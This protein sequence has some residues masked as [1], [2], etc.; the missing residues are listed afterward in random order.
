MFLVRHEAQQG[1][2]WTTWLE[3]VNG[4]LPAAAVHGACCR[5]DA[6]HRVSVR[7]PAVRHSA[8]PSDRRRGSFS[9]WRQSC[10]SIVLYPLPRIS[11]H[12]NAEQDLAALIAHLGMTAS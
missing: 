7:P 4:L 8:V 11:V 1:A 6:A 3:S 9:R 12:V 10:S 5:G 2:L